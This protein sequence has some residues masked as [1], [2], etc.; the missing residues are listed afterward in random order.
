M[1]GILGYV[2]LK[3]EARPSGE[4]FERA[5]ATLARRGPDDRGTWADGNAILGHTRLAIID[6]S[7][8]GHQPM[9]SED[10]RYVTVFNGEI[11]NYRELRRELEQLG[12]TF[13]SSSDTEVMLELFKREGVKCASRFRGMFALAIWDRQESELFLL[14]DRLG[15]KPLYIWR[16]GAGIAFASEVK[17]LSAL[18]GGPS[19]VEPTA[20]F[21]YLAWGS[22]P[23]TLAAVRGVESI[24]PATWA[25]WKAGS[26]QQERYWSIPEGDIQYRTADAAVE[27]LR[28]ALV[29]AVGLRCVA[30]VGVG[31]FLSGGIDSSAVVALMRAAGQKNLHTFSVSFP[32]S[33]LD[34]SVYAQAVAREY[35]TRHVSLPVTDR[36]ADDILDDFFDVMDQPTCDGLNTY[37]VS[38]LAKEAGLT[39]ALSGL[40]GDEV[41]GGYAS[42]H[43]ARQLERWLEAVPSALLGG[44]GKGLSRLHPRLG[45]LEVF[46]SGDDLRAQGYFLSRGMF[47][48]SVC[49]RLMA[50]S[51]KEPNCVM[52]ALPTLPKSVAPFHATMRLELAMYMHNQ[53]LKDSDVFG[54]AHALE[55]RVPLI[56]HK[57]VELIARTDDSVLA[58]ASNKALLRDALPRPLPSIC[59]NRPKMGFAFPFERWMRT[60]WRPEI[61]AELMAGRCELLDTE[62]VRKIWLQFMAGRLH[63]SR[64]WALYTI[65]RWARRVRARPAQDAGD[66]ALGGA[67]LGSSL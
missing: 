33:D 2:A 10:G 13:R 22:V 18:Q 46:G 54:M 4:A 30:D 42:F 56:D 52:P 39:V 63:W 6:L 11:Y 31:A 60:T 57:L 40:G 24:A 27:A 17:A 62:A 65:C 9:H 16:H 21:Q 26:F 1:C 3:R 19:E 36:L 58:A 12:A 32:G 47:A 64:P 67:L 48:P 23:S 34:E 7:P 37:I 51:L 5:L 43:R 28:P 15:V 8:A 41:F 38:R 53:L 45:K 50:D 44:V 49:Q 55:I 20:L 66:R 59:V 29:E 35:G 25:H 61:E 14:R